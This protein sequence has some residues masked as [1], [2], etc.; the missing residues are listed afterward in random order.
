M[1]LVEEGGVYTPHCRPLEDKMEGEQGI[2]SMIKL[3]IWNAI[4]VGISHQS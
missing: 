2:R 3:L 1:Q 4:Y